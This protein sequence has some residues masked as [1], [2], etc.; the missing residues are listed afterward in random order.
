MAAAF[1]DKLMAYDVEPEEWRKL[2]VSVGEPAADDFCDNSIKTYK[3]N[4][5]SW[6]PKSLFEQMRR[7]RRREIVLRAE[8]AE[9]EWWC[10]SVGAARAGPT[11]YLD[12]ITWSHRLVRP[13]LAP[14][15]SPETPHCRRLSRPPRT[16]PRARPPSPY[17]AQAPAPPA[18]RPL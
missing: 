7:L 14:K 3:Y 10:S 11:K 4:P 15:R 13:L 5:I 6:L 8:D 18:P 12:I 9:D 16:D 17:N 1:C 2:D